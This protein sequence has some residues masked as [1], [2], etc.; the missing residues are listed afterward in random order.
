MCLIP[1]HAF[2]PFPEP[3]FYLRYFIEAGPLFHIFT[4]I[5]MT[6]V[7]G[8]FYQIYRGHRIANDPDRRNQLK[9]LFVAF[10]F[11]YGGGISNF[12]WVYG[13]NVWP[14]N[15]FGTYGVPI[16]FAILT[17][18]IVR[19]HLIDI[20]V[21]IRKSAIYSALIGIITAI[22]FG[23]VY[24]TSLSFGATIHMISGRQSVAIT[25][26]AMILI[27]LLF[28]PTERRIQR[29][30]DRYFFKDTAEAITRENERLRAE[31]VRAEQM[32]AV[33]LLASG[34]A[35]EIKNPLTAIKTFV[36]HLNDRYQ[37]PEYR[38]KFQR[39][40]TAEI[41]KINNTVRQLLTFAKPQPTEFHEV[42]LSQLLD[43]TLDLL[44]NDLVTHRIQVERFYD[45]ADTIRGDATQ[46]KQAFLNLFLNSVDAMNGSGGKLTVTT[47]S[48][49]GSV[50][51]TIADTGC[52]IP[53]DK[54]H[55]IFEPF[56]TTKPT[57]TGLGLSVVQHI[58]IT[59]G[60]FIEVRSIPK[61]ST[62][63]TINFPK[64]LNSKHMQP[65]DTKHSPC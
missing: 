1:S 41:E 54:L 46:L 38:A 51:A 53:Q 49:N 25:L 19:H 56:F 34:M 57:G 45:G 47:A 44:S 39:I 35:H 61:I 28:K 11:G 60:G 58:F 9:Y 33:S 17:Y 2:L 65:L 18:A 27:A 50:T 14:Y 52:G 8:T 5:W 21:V 22:Y 29:F 55:C 26:L 12:L 30:L 13:I 63:F 59:H 23:V 4:A 64:H 3:K 16:Y 42:K 10:F 40:V 7:L 24:L 48:S 6:M 62:A 36:E 20:N 15:P 31:M 32:K 43:E 37:D